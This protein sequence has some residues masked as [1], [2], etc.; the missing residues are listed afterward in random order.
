MPIRDLYSGT[1]IEILKLPQKN[2]MA[3]RKILNKAKSIRSIKEFDDQ[4]SNSDS[5]QQSIA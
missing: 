5:D 4:H 1:Q 3:V 2:A